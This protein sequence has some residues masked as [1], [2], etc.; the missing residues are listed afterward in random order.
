MVQTKSEQL[1]ALCD[2]L[3]AHRTV[4]LQSWR[5]SVDADPAQTT[6]HALTRGQ[7]NDHIPE[8]LDAF[9]WKLRSRPGGAE[10]NAADVE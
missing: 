10:A 3:A 6:A 5:N 9:E 8:V 2:L 4:L 1:N 7:F